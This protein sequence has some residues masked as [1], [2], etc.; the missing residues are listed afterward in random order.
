MFFTSNE[1][2]LS[3]AEELTKVYKG[4]EFRSL[5]SDKYYGRKIYGD[6]ISKTAMLME[7]INKISFGDGRVIHAW[8]KVRIDDYLAIEKLTA[9][10]GDHPVYLGWI[11][12]T[13][14]LKKNHDV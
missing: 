10:T 4:V 3:V 7:R 6:L 11:P 2:A 5:S 9:L 8:D 12:I 14:V 13:R 1:E